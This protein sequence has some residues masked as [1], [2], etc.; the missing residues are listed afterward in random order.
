MG[1]GSLD[2]LG[3]QQNVGSRVVAIHMSISRY[4]GC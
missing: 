4:G 3:R 1:G 2:P